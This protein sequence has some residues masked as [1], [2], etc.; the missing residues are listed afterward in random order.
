MALY[1]TWAGASPRLFYLEPG[2]VAPAAFPFVATI[3]AEPRE[4]ERGH[5]APFSTLPDL[6]QNDSRQS[7]AGQNAHIMNGEWLRAVP[8]TA[9]KKAAQH[10]RAA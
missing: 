1:R 2:R 8:D 7:G 9:D 5:M 10:G 3:A 4:R 6:C